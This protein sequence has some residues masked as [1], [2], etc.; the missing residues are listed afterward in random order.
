VANFQTVIA[1]VAVLS[2]VFL[3]FTQL[4][5]AQSGEPLCVD[6]TSAPTEAP[7]LSDP[8]AG[9]LGGT[10]ESFEARFGPPLE[11]SN[12]SIRYDLEGCADMY[13]SYEEGRLTDVDFFGPG[14]LEMEGEW[15]FSQAMQIA[16]RLLPLDVE[17]R[18]P[19]RNVS[20]VEH[21]PCMSTALAEQVP[22]SVYAFVDNNP[23]QGQCS[24]SY[25][26]DDAGDVI[27]F[28]VQLEVED[29]P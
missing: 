4:A 16:N 26:F 17:Q 12:L 11:E 9:R 18:E 8:L 19:F 27:S 15:S 29:A 13:V 22:E 20:F 28:T 1:R 25:E 7:E 14:V 10:R 23:V 2:V 21:Q 5:H 6:F 24:A 3:S